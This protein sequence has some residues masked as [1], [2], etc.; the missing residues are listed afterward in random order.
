MQTGGAIEQILDTSPVQNIID[1]EE[2]T[3]GEALA[4]D[5]NNI[6]VFPIV[7]VKELSTLQFSD[8]GFYFDRTSGA[9]D[10]TLGASTQRFEIKGTAPMYLIRASSL[11]F[12][13]DPAIRIFAV[14]HEGTDEATMKSKAILI[15]FVG[16]PG[17]LT[18]L[19]AALPKP[20]YNW[21]QLI[22]QMK[23]AD[24]SMNVTLTSSENKE[25]LTIGPVA[26]AIKRT[27]P[28]HVHVIDSKTVEKFNGRAAFNQA[29]TKITSWFVSDKRIGLVPDEQ[30]EQVQRLPTYDE[31]FH[32]IANREDEIFQIQPAGGKRRKSRKT[33][34]LRKTKRSCLK[35]KTLE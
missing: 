25:Y 15:P 1:A 7:S 32:F 34:A 16:A 24:P 22:V 2:S 30:F 11:Q 10:V 31:R 12:I 20:L 18:P 9:I 17:S 29:F 14:L 23:G 35:R 26:L 33:I 21:R 3:V 13:L 4:A 8:N 28:H 19:A 5:A 27:S 6:I